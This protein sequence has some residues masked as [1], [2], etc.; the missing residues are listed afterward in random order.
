MCIR[1]SRIGFQAVDIGAGGRAERHIATHDVP[2]PDHL[3]AFQRHADDIGAVEVFAEDTGRNRIAVEA[4][5]EVEQRRAVADENVFP[6]RNRAEDFLGKVKGIVGALF[7]RCLLY[8][9]RCV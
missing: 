8:T 7:K 5:Q 6:V 4:D 2:D 9:S 1:D 3:F